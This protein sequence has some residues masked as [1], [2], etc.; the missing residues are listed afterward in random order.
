MNESRLSVSSDLAALS[1]LARRLSEPWPA[2]RAVWD[3]RERFRYLGDVSIVRRHMFPHVLKSWPS[4]HE[5]SREPRQR[6]HLENPASRPGPAG[7]SIASV[8]PI[9]FRWP[10]ETVQPEPEVWRTYEAIS[11]RIECNYGT[12]RT[13]GWFLMVPLQHRADAEVAVS[14]AHEV[15]SPWDDLDAFARAIADRLAPQPVHLP[16]I[17]HPRRLKHGIRGARRRRSRARWSTGLDRAT[18]G[19]LAARYCTRRLDGSYN[20]HDARRWMRQFRAVAIVAGDAIECWGLAGRPLAIRTLLEIVGLADAVRL[21]ERPTLET[22]SNAP[23]HQIRHAAPPPGF[24]LN[25]AWAAEMPEYPQAGGGILGHTCAIPASDP[26]L[27]CQQRTIFA[28][29][30]DTSGILIGRAPR[31]EEIARLEILLHNAAQLP[32]MGPMFNADEMGRRAIDPAV[33]GAP[34]NARPTMRD[35]EATRFAVHAPLL[36]R[37]RFS[38]GWAADGSC[39]VCGCEGPCEHGALPYFPEAVT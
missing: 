24:A 26:C 1:A 8:G 21:T 16:A 14:K 4:R 15:A 38:I 2:E 13:G 18:L 35:I 30:S 17:V 20:R 33:H 23:I 36:D 29:E 19:S 27:A 32:R 28:A 5:A 10:A 11:S 37:S 22:W 7:S 9:V 6:H 31:P 3:A 12:L 34:Q 25:A 39:S